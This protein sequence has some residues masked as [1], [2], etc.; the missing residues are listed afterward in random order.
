[1]YL[2]FPGLITAMS[3]GLVRRNFEPGFDSVGSH[4]YSV[5]GSQME[6]VPG[7]VLFM[8]PTPIL[9]DVDIVDAYGYYGDYS[10]V[11]NYGY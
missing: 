8:K 9:P 7:A 10:S 6:H 1:M 3:Y 11:D 2:F 5:H 4:Q